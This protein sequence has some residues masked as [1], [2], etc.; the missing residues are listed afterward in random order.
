MITKI[1][2][3]YQQNFQG[4]A[5]IKGKPHEV[6]EIAGKIKEVLPDSFVFSNKKH[7]HKKTYFI[8]TGKHQDKF[9]DLFGQVEL[10]DLKQNI[11]KHMGIKAKKLSLEDVQKRLKKDK[12]K[13]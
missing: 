4:F 2:S 5:K 11:E 9:M 7:H 12:F 3:S 8:L 1:N 13:I 10:F 6:R